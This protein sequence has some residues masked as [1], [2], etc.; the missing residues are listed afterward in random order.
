MWCRAAQALKTVGIKLIFSS[1]LTRNNSVPVVTMWFTQWAHLSLKLP[2]FTSNLCY[3]GGPVGLR[4]W[5]ISLPRGLPM[6]GVRRDGGAM[7]L[8][9]P[10][11]G[12][13]GNCGGPRTGRFIIGALPR[14]LEKPVEVRFCILEPVFFWPLLSFYSEERISNNIV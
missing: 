5:G 4:S 7:G 6:S 2:C 3:L 1:R 9:P 10:N 13:T 12:F 14:F 8:L 11:S